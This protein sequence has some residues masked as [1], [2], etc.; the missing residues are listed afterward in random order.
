M[1][2]AEPAS[3]EAQSSAIHKRG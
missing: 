3:T 1:L 2:R